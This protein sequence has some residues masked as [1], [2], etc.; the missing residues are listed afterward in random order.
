MPL[1][2]ATHDKDAVPVQHTKMIHHYMGMLDCSFNDNAQPCRYPNNAP[3]FFCFPNY[4]SIYPDRQYTL[5]F[6]IKSVM[7]MGPVVCVGK[8][9]IF[10]SSAKKNK[11]PFLQLSSFEGN[12]ISTVFDKLWK[13]KAIDKLRKTETGSRKLS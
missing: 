9:S 8:G 10:C 4:L 3:N 6:C 12:D 1:L 5:A 7:P 2:F 11:A 13:G